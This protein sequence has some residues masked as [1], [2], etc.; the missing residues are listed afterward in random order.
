[1]NI[2]QYEITEKKT[3]ATELHEIIFESNTTAVKGYMQ[4]YRL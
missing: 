2:L 4:N 3:L 1:M